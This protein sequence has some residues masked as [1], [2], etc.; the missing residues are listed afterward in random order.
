MLQS[1]LADRFKLVVHREARE[2]R[3]AA[4]VIGKG[5]PRL[6]NPPRR[7]RKIPVS[8]RASPEVDRALPTQRRW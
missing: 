6:W 7:R 2:Q 1:L 3:A 8:R 4:L 5:G